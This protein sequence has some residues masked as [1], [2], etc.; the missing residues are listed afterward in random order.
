MRFS[1]MTV[2]LLM[3]LAGCRSPWCCQP[4]AGCPMASPTVMTAMNATDSASLGITAAIRH[5]T[6]ADGILARVEMTNKGKAP[7]VLNVC[8]AME[9]CCVRGLHPMLEYDDTGMGL[10]D[11]CKVAKPTPQSVYLPAGAAFSFDMTI[12]VDH[13]P[14]GVE[15][16]PLE[17][18]RI[19]IRL[20]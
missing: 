13:L 5:A 12:P 9:L 1:C 10:L 18:A 3:V 7:Q 16:H 2:G 4:K 17:S 19:Q 6:R 14:D 15:G 8:P 20:E 11:L